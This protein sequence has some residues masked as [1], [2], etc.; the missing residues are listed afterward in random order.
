M[1]TKKPTITKRQRA[2]FALNKL[3]DSLQSDVLADSATRE[4]WDINIQRIIPVIDGFPMEWTTLLSAFR[5]VAD[6]KTVSNLTDVKGNKLEASISMDAEGAV[7]IQAATQRLRFSHAILIASDLSVRLAALEKMFVD[8]TLSAPEQERL[9]KIVGRES[10]SFEDF[11][12]VTE[13]LAASPQEF[14]VRLGEKA[15]TRRVALGDVLPDD[16][17]HW[18]NLT[19]ARVN[20]VTL[21]AFIDDELATERKVRLAFNPVAAFRSIAYLFCA[22]TRPI[23]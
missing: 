5:A 15:N 10:F 4:L 7:L 9:R 21:A 3:S 1:M 16:A 22:V 2:L 19:A 18:S 11:M 17:R 6:G 13:A 8:T 23:R 20:S 14:S 12:Q